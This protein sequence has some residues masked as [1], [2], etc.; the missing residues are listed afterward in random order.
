MKRI[1]AILICT[2]ILL[3]GCNT[4]NTENSQISS[5][6]DGLKQTSEASENGANDS[7]QSLTTEAESEIESEI[8]IENE[9]SINDNSPESDTDSSTPTYNGTGTDACYATFDF[10]TW[11]ELIEDD[12]YSIQKDVI[13]GVKYDFDGQKLMDFLSAEK[14]TVSEF[15]MRFSVV[16]E[17]LKL[18]M[19]KN[20][21]QNLQ[22]LK[23]F[24]AS[25]Y[26][27][28][29]TETHDFWFWIKRATR[30]DE[31]EICEIDEA[32]WQKPAHTVGHKY[33]KVYK[34]TKEGVDIYVVPDSDNYE[35]YF[36]I[37]G[38][39]F[40]SDNTFTCYHYLGKTQ[41]ERDELLKDYKEYAF[42]YEL[43]S[44]ETESSELIRTLKEILPE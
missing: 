3:C 27:Y 10:A 22:Y 16:T 28:P 9:S 34:Y 32:P 20:P 18:D 17:E 12:S 19:K 26:I 25:T 36:Q 4:A 42:F 33:K 1:I 7:S 6:A 38:F 21:H 11:Q 30:G 41:E 43:F 35:V 13:Q 39:L 40:K 23:G 15:H 37:G 8:E 44:P 24:F 29:L 31:F 5:E 14:V 2:F